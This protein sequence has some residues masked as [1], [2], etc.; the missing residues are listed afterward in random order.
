LRSRY[1]VPM[2]EGPR[3]ARIAELIGDRARAEMLTA[4]LDGRALA[5]GE[6]AAAAGITASTA[7]AHLARLADAGLV[8]GVRQGRHRYFRLAN[9]EVAQLIEALAGAAARQAGTPLRPGPREPSLREARVCYDHLAGARAVRAADALVARGLLVDHDGQWSLG[10]GALVWF[11]R[12]LGLDVAGLRAGRRPLCRSCLDWSERRPHL[13]G[14]LG[15]ALLERLLAL[16]WARR[17]EGSRVVLFTP[18]GELAWRAHFAA[19]ANSVGAAA[20]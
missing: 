8:V 6:L 9:A 16:H 5:A 2:S 18:A 4:L 10:D 17:V 1:D 3:I 15:A 14:A 13:A 20:A 12:T 11:E 19:P 7:S